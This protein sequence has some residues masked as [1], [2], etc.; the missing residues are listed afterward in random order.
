MAGTVRGG[1]VTISRSSPPLLEA[2]ESW[3]G[4]TEAFPVG[5]S[6]PTGTS[7]GLL[8]TNNSE[9]GDELMLPDGR[10]A[11]SLEEPGGARLGLAGK[12]R[13]HPYPRLRGGR[14][15]RSRLKQEPSCSIQGHRQFPLRLMHTRQ[16]VLVQVG[17]NCGAAERR[18]HHARDTAPPAGPSSKNPRSTVGNCFRVVSA[19]PHPVRGHS[20]EKP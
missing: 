10:E 11:D 9:A 8:G 17:E 16:C 1:I 14:V 2:L 5:S 3:G 15:H 19:R 13:E 4:E 6:C 18:Q 12:L 20:A 7:A